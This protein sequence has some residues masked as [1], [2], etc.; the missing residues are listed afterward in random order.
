[1]K[2]YTTIT[3]INRK[4]E[5]RWAIRQEYQFLNLGLCTTFLEVTEVYFPVFP[6]L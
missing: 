1:M 3:F 5:R 2:T 6:K 4:A